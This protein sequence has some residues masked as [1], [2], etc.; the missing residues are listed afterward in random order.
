MASTRSIQQFSKDSKVYG[1][2]STMLYPCLLP[3]IHWSSLKIPQHP[4][5][6]QHFFGSRDAERWGTWVPLRPLPRYRPA[7]CR[8]NAQ[9]FWQFDASIADTYHTPVMLIVNQ[10][11]SHKPFLSNHLCCLK[12][13]KYA[14]T[15][16]KTSILLGTTM[17]HVSLTSSGDASTLAYAVWSSNSNLL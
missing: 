17:Q 3:D 16:V 7:G 10:L 13:F 5:T 6:A 11:S 2:G 12:L 8:S 4:S 15:L 14:S 9:H 1:L